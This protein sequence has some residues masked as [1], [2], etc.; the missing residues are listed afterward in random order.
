M[1]RTVDTLIFALVI[2]VVEISQHF[3]GRDVGAGVI[4]DTFA[5]IFDEVFQ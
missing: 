4:D 3:H 5:P 1:L 2:N